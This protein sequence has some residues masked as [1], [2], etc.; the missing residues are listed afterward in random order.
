MKFRE[1]KNKLSYVFKLHLLTLKNLKFIILDK[2]KKI[3]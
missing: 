1:G 3:K 2:L